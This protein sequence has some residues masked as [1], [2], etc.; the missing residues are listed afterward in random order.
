M[1]RAAIALTFLVL[2]LALRVGAQD[3]P[4]ASPAEGLAFLAGDW[5]SRSAGESFRA[6]YSDPEGGMV[7]GVSKSVAKGKAVFFEL[8][9]FRVA[10]QELVLQPYPGGKAAASFRASKLEKNSVTFANPNNEFPKEITYACPAK[11]QLEITLRGGGKERRFALRR[12]S[13]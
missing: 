4:P 6:H 7:V 8:E 12:L 11:D 13:R 9:V 1:K 3:S 10:G 5:E 2:L